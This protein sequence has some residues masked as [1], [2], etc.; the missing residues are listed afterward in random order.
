MYE[1]SLAYK[2]HDHLICGDCEKVFAFCDPRLYLVQTTV[3]KLMNF[4]I[5]QHSLNFFGK[6]NKLSQTG[7]CE[8]LNKKKK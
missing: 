2:Q 5:T 6:C 8:H 1:R 3:E 4:N 7:S